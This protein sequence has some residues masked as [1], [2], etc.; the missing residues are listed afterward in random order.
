MVLVEGLIAAYF[1]LIST[2]PNN[3]NDEGLNSLLDIVYRIGSYFSKS[4]LGKKFN[5]DPVL[6]FFVDE[7]VTPAIRELVGRGVNMGAFV[8]TREGRTAGAVSRRRPPYRI[9]DLAG[10]KV[11]LSNTFAPHFRIPLAGGRTINLSTILERG[12]LSTPE[13]PLLELFGEKI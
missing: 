2:V 3:P 9:G 1:A 8:T 13:K 7:K 6:S 11:R 10:L 5:P 4:V 12:A